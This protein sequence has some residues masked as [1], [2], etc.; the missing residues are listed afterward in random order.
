MLLPSIPKGLCNQRLRWVQD[1]MAAH[2]LSAAVV[3][4][5][6]VYSRKNCHFDSRCYKEYSASV[7]FEEAFDVGLTSRALAAAGVCVLSAS[8]A[9]TRFPSVTPPVLEDK[10]TLPTS[11]TELRARRESIA[12][13]VAGRVWSLAGEAACCTLVVPDSMRSAALWRRVNAAF[14]P[15]PS[16]RSLAQEVV[17]LF[18]QRT[19]EASAVGIA[20]HWRGQPDMTGPDHLLNATGYSFQTARALVKMRNE[21]RDCAAG[22]RC[23]EPASLSLLA[24]GGFSAST[25]EQLRLSLVS[26]LTGLGEDA[27][28]RSLALHSKETLLPI[29]YGR[30]YGGNDDI[31]GLLDFEVARLAPAFVGSPFS[32]FSVVAAAARRG[33]RLRSEAGEEPPTSMIAAD[34]SDRIAAIFALHVPYQLED[35]R[36]DPCAALQELHHSFRPGW[37]C[38][39]AAAPPPFSARPRHRHEQCD[40]LA[41]AEMRIEPAVDAPDRLGFN[42]TL[43]VVTSVFNNYDLLPFYNLGFASRLRQQEQERRVRTCWFA[44]TDAASIGPLLPSQQSVKLAAA[45]AA[46]GTASN[47]NCAH[48][49]RQ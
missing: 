38:P 43:A 5:S 46:G 7:L 20:L 48:G 21:V 27:L 22:R 12:S 32:S 42:C 37:S 47:S 3:L 15:A 28:G 33:R 25:L 24:L 45:A 17:Q 1:V 13:A 31:V 36:A 16:L 18:R 34:V 35:V 10:L 6:E 4:P 26:A 19:L 40:A 30:R 14:T 23:A 39:T 11:M 8:E 9:V 41:G 44:F 29:D 2:A 49:T